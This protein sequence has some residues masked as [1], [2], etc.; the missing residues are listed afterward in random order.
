MLSIDNDNLYAVLLFL[1]T[2]TSGMKR[3]VLNTEFDKIII[4]LVYGVHDI[5]D[6]RQS[7]ITYNRFNSA[8]VDI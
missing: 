6:I 5:D 7:Q 8:G 4:K 3:V 1:L 2:N